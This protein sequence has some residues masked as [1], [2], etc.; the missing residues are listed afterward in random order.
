MR[1]LM[2]PPDYYGIEYEINPWMSR[3][4]QSNP[5]LAREEWE[6]LYRLLRVQLAAAIEIIE[7]QPDL[8]DMVF[9]ANAGL[10]WQNRFIASQFRPEVRRDESY[11][12]ET[13]FANQGFD[14]HHLPENH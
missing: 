10:V 4:R 13:W 8:P 6:K 7:P 2:C 1:L 12:Y 9:T 5:Q 3:S 14:I 11:F